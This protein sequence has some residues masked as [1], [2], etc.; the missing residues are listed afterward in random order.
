V[1]LTPP[2]VPESRITGLR[3][4]ASDDAALAAT[5]LRL[6]SMPEP[7]RRAMGVRGRE[8][9]L[10]HFD[11]PTVAAQTLRLYAQAVSGQTRAAAGGPT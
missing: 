10:G 5:L 11:G 6:F 9:V 4:P 1:V 2:A 3:F 8:W 7:T